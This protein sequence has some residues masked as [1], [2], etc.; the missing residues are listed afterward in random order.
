VLGKLEI[1]MPLQ[2]SSEMTP[3]VITTYDYSPLSRLR[4]IKYFREYSD[5]PQYQ[6][7]RERR[8]R[9]EDCREDCSDAGYRTS[10]H[11]C[12]DENNESITVRTFWF[13]D[14]PIRSPPSSPTDNEIISDAISMIIPCKAPLTAREQRIQS[15]KCRD[16]IQQQEKCLEFYKPVVVSSA[17]SDAEETHPVHSQTY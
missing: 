13:N 17:S 10:D 5:E 3:D 7:W 14:S 12:P 6:E 8:D 11:D 1:E 2:K 15:R 4:A 9:R 16:F